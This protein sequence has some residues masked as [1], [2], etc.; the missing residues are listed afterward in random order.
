MPRSFFNLF[1]FHVVV[2]FYSSFAV[3]DGKVTP[4]TKANKSYQ[5]PCACTSVKSCWSGSVCNPKETK[6]QLMCKC[7]P[8]AAHLCYDAKTGEVEQ[9]ESAVLFG[10]F[11]DTTTAGQSRKVM[12]SPTGQGAQ[13]IQY[14]QLECKGTATKTDLLPPAWKDNMRYRSTCM[15]GKAYATAAAAT[16]AGSPAPAPAPVSAATTTA[17]TSLALATAAFV[18]AMM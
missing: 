14:P 8:T 5:E 10:C 17:M 3:Q 13:L 9:P 16:A 12:C 7:T 18:A 6:D 4:F 1:F 15:N 2:I 11:A